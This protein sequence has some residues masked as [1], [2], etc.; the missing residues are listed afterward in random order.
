MNNVD[1]TLSTLDPQ[2]KSICRS[3]EA[4]TSF[5]RQQFLGFEAD[6]C[7]SNRQ[8]KFFG[9]DLRVVTGLRKAGEHG[10]KQILSK[11]S[12]TVDEYFK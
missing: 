8:T 7:L 10:F 6:L 11:N 4:N 9:L 3:A 1:I 12:H 5:T 2:N